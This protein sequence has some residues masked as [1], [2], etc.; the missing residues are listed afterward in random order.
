MIWSGV[1]QLS[2]TGS[3]PSGV[4]IGGLI[5]WELRSSASAGTGRD[6]W[7]TARTAS[8]PPGARAGCPD[9][10]PGPVGRAGPVTGWEANGRL[11]GVVGR[12]ANVGMAGV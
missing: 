1:C 7:G 6:G 12:T 2:G 9:V 8:R 5:G 11:A 10:A 4:T 3:Q